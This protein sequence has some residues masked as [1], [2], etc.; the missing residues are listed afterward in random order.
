MAPVG[1]LALARRVERDRAAAVVGLVD[2]ALWPVW[3][4]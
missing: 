2:E 3:G 4:G 1:R